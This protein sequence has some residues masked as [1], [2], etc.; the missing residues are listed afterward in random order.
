MGRPTERKRPTCGTTIAKRGWWCSRDLGHDGP[1][2]ARPIPTPWGL[3]K[4]A[5][6]RRL[7]DRRL[8]VDAAVQLQ[9]ARRLRMSDLAALGKMSQ[10]VTELEETL[11]AERAQRAAIS[12]DQAEGLTVP[13]PWSLM[14]ELKQH[15]LTLADVGVV[16]SMVDSDGAA[17]TLAKL[18]RC[19][20]LAVAPEERMGLAEAALGDGMKPAALADALDQMQAK[21]THR[22]ADALARAATVLRGGDP[23]E[24]V[25]AL[26][27]VSQVPET[28]MVTV[29][30]PNPVAAVSDGG[31]AQK[32]SLQVYLNFM[33]DAELQPGR[34][35][36]AVTVVAHGVEASVTVTPTWR[37]AE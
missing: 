6:L 15:L 4:D 24:T 34:P 25:R 31:P 33:A 22:Y 35:N 12:E 3:L 29:D 37:E 27:G 7:P 23:D 18:D 32:R 8:L 17:A 16:I 9:D 10:R 14:V 19:A 11:R 1:C 5:I 30:L 21:L 36:P 13:I 2:A 28:V 26:F 20:I